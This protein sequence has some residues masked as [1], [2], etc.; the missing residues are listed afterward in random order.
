MLANSLDR[1]FIAEHQ[2]RLFVFAEY[3]TASDNNGSKPYASKGH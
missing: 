2:P 1:R 3:A